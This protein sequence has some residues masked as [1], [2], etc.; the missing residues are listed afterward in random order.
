MT[1]HFGDFRFDA[2]ERLLFRGADR[3]P[4]VPKVADTLHVLLERHGQVIEKAELMQRI[5]PDA[6]VEEIGLARNIS[7]LRKALDD[8]APDSPIIE[9]VPR[10]GYRFAAPVTVG[11]PS[12]PRKKRSLAPIAAAV[13]LLAT[14]VV[15]YY[16]FYVP[17]RFV[18]PNRAAAL[19]VVPFP[20]ACPGIDAD[21][22]TDAL[23]DLL[24]TDLSQT[25]TLQLVAPSTVRRHQR[26]GMSMGLM[27]RLLGLDALVEGS[28]QLAGP[29]LRTTVRLVDVHTGKVIWSETIH[30]PAANPAAAQTATARHAATQIAARLLNH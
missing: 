28:V 15:I 30:Q 13:L 23:T 29:D 12:A 2:T 27:G 11:T 8:E 21:A 4:L 14:A 22:Y 6:T 20:C 9:T 24:V 18:S 16:Q 10:R 3:V 17:S 1:Y 26:A 19:A 25:P 5:W 7:L